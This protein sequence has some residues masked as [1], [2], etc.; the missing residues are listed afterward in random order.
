MIKAVSLTCHSSPARLTTG[1]QSGPMT[2]DCGHLRVFSQCSEGTPKWANMIKDLP[3]LFF[4]VEAS[5]RSADRGNVISLDRNASLVHCCICAW[6]LTCSFAETLSRCSICL[7]KCIANV[8]WLWGAVM[9]CNRNRKHSW[10]NAESESSKSREGTGSDRHQSEQP[11]FQAGVGKCQALQNKSLPT[12]H[13]WD[14][15]RRDQI[16][17]IN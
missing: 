8:L 3:C 10:I 1:S 2:T 13:G 4:V 15:V 14:W 11:V 7:T 12:K 6:H 16:S 9:P 5:R 17:E